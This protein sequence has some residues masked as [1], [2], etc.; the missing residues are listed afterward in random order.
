MLERKDLRSGKLILRHSQSSSRN[1]NDKK[2]TLVPALVGRVFEQFRSELPDVN[3]VCSDGNSE[4]LSARAGVTQ[5]LRPSVTASILGLKEEAAGKIVSELGYANLAMG[6]IGILS[7]AFPAW[8]APAALAG[9][10]F[11]GL[12]GIKH[13]SHANRSAKENLA[14]ATD[15][16]VACV[17]AAYLSAVAMR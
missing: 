14:M 12:A 17:A 6:S 2:S 8:L 13:A 1:S 11:L 15:L 5:V 16:L 4:I 10:L 3:L 9:G 7:L